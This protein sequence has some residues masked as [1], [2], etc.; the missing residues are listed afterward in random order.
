MR[1][2]VDFLLPLKLQK[3]CYFGLCRKKLLANHFAGFFTFDLFNL[4]ILIPGIHSYIRLV[5]ISVIIT[6]I[7]IIIIIIIIIVLYLT[8]VKIQVMIK[9]VVK[10]TVYNWVYIHLIKN[11]ISK[12][13]I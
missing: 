12:T 8:S 7:I 2:Q 9:P 10:A 3:I 5:V 13:T 1:Y 11:K 4:L 6:V